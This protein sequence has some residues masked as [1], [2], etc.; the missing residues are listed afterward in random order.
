MNQHTAKLITKSG[1]NV[2]RIYLS[3]ILNT[4]TI[5]NLLVAKI[6]FLGR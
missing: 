4:S 2:R 5:A 6:H 1:M 3:T